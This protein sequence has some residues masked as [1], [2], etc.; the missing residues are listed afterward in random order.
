MS[1]VKK[2]IEHSRAFPTQ[3][4]PEWIEFRKTRITGSE[5]ATVICQNK[6]QTR[7]SLLAKK[8]CTQPIH[9]DAPALEHGR[10]YEPIAIKKY[11]EQ[12]GEKVHELNMIGAPGNDRF[13][14]SPDG[15]TESGR[16]IE[17]KCPFAREIKHEVPTYYMPQIQMGLW[18][19]SMHGLDTVCDFIQYKPA[20]EGRGEILDILEVARDPSWFESN[21]AYIMTFL[22][23]LDSP[24]TEAEQ[25]AMD[26]SAKFQSFSRLNFSVEKS[27]ECLIVDD[28]PPMRLR[29]IQHNTS[30]CLIDD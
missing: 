8:R 1:I 27:T 20:T 3:R 13:A 7:K 19:L 28:D 21:K 17:V 18:I 6:Y 24:V 26:E 15:L 23:D 4:T 25:R 2:I 5:V 16:L 14:Y 29:K 12:T 22:D 11:E 10:K 9:I 30:E